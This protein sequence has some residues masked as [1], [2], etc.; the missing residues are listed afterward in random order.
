MYVILNGHSVWPNS[1]Q[2]S[3][4]QVQKHE[5]DASHVLLQTSHLVT[6]AYIERAVLVL[7]LYRYIGLRWTCIFA[8]N[9]ALRLLVWLLNRI[10]CVLVDEINALV[11]VLLSLTSLEAKLSGAPIASKVNLLFTWLKRV[12]LAW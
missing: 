9:R 12:Q 2:L 5:V 4:L 8:G 7:T 6:H 3:T 10:A 11:G 1:S